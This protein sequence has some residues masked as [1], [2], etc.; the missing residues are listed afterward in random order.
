MMRLDFT[1]ENKLGELPK[2][3]DQLDKLRSDW[4]LCSKTV[5]QINLILEELFSNIV[6]HG[7]SKAS[8]HVEFS[9][10][11][12]MSELQITVTDNG[13]AFDMTCSET[14]DTSLPLEQRKCGGLGILLVQKICDSCHYA[15]E[16]GK[17]TITLIKNLP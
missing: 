13:P 3:H 17:N 11:K 16:K 8:Y 9:I 5:F 7:N 2:L 6:L 1:L 4:Q 14:P 12:L 15:R 10:Q